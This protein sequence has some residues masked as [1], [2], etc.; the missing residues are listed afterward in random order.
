MKQ[1]SE[2]Q[3]S[4]GRIEGGIIELKN[5]LTLLRTDHAS[6]RE[7]FTKMESGRLTKLESSFAVMESNMHA[8]AKSTAMFFSFITAIVVSVITAVLIHYLGL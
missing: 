6:L 7:E 1:D 5:S 4:L 2:T 3:R 8:K